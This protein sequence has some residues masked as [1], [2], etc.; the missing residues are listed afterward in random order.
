MSTCERWL[1]SN[2]SSRIVP[3]GR[4]VRGSFLR[5]ARF[6]LRSWQGTT[7]GMAGF[8]GGFRSKVAAE[9][10]QQQNS[11]LG[12][13]RPGEFSSP[14]S[15][16]TSEL[17]GYNTRYGGIARAIQKRG[18]KARGAHAGGGLI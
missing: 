16:S 11:P 15:F 18:E 12:A 8:G 7:R 10:R 5:R 17:A 2:G 14:S 4:C 9:Q 13:V 1:L 6:R 3:S